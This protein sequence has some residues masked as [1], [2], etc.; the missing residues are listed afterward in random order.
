MVSLISRGVGSLFV[1]LL[2]VFLSLLMVLPMG[3]LEVIG[4]CGKALFPFLFVLVMEACSRMLDKAVLERR[5]LGFN[6][7]AIAW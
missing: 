3:S 7:G 5:L 6:A 4:G 1:Y 2:F